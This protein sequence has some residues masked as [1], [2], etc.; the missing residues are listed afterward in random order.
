MGTSTKVLDIPIETLVLL[1]ADIERC[2]EWQ[3]G[4]IESRT[5]DTQGTTPVEGVPAECTAYQRYQLA[6]PLQNRDY[7]YKGVWTFEGWDDGKKKAKY[8]V[9]SCSFDG[10]PATQSSVV[11]G[12]LNPNVWEFEEVDGGKTQVTL[13][14]NADPGGNMPVFGEALSACVSFLPV[15]IA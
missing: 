9:K 5:L 3:S 1:C 4:C 6:C 15:C 7:T 2:T 11:R 13:T 14:I 8:D 12:V 10:A